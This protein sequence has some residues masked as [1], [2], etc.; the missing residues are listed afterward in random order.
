[1]VAV[2]GAAVPRG[3]A[4]TAAAKDAVRALSG[5]LGI[6]LCDSRVSGVPII[7]PFPHVAAHVM[8][9]QFVGFFLA[10]ELGLDAVIPSNFVRVITSSIQVAFALNAATSS[11]LPLR[12]R[13]QAIR[14]ARQRVEFRN[15]LLTVVP[16]HVFYGQVIALETAGIVAHDRNPLG[17]RHRVFPDAEIGQCDFVL[18]F[19]SV[20]VGF[21][22]RAAHQKRAALDEDHF[23][24]N[25]NRYCFS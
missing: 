19:V 3:A 13:W 21:A 17:L 22:F 10:R 9:A 2:R 12:F 23:W 16:I 20:P 18:G 15:E 14:F 4:P 1:M 6:R 25:H 7:A 24:L 5:D 11:K 8:E